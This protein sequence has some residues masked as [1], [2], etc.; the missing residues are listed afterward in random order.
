MKIDNIIPSELKVVASEHL[1][2]QQDL[3]AVDSEKPIELLIHEEEK[4]KQ[5]SQG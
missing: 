3:Q 1:N 5:S 2:I 4:T